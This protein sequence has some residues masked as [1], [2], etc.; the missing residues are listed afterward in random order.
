MSTLFT[1]TNKNDIKRISSREVHNLSPVV[2]SFGSAVDEPRGF[3]LPFLPLLYHSQC[4]PLR[5]GLIFKEPTNWDSLPLMK[6]MQGNL[7]LWDSV[8]RWTSKLVDFFFLGRSWSGYKYRTAWRICKFVLKLLLVF[9]LIT[10][11]HVLHQYTLMP[12]KWNTNQ[13]TKK[14]MYIK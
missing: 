10:L 7:N 9:K 1:V 6:R 4:L 8:E 12:R 3:S 13:W 11:Y 2:S 14:I 5:T